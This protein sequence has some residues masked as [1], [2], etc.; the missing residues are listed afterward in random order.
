MKIR[1]FRLFQALCLMA[2]LTACGSGRCPRGVN[3]SD[4]SCPGYYSGRT[5]RTPSYDYSNGD[6]GDYYY[7]EDPYAYDYGSG[8]ELPYPGVGSSSSYPTGNSSS[9]NPYGF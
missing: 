2:L 9:T 7:D 1:V 8:Y 5:Y 3:T 4:P 6:Q